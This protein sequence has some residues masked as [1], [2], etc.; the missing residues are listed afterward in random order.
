MTQGRENQNTDPRGSLGR[1]PIFP[2]MQSMSAL[3]MLS[4]S[5]LPPT[6]GRCLVANG[7]K[8]LGTS[9]GAMPTPSSCT[10]YSS[11]KSPPTAAL[12]SAPFLLSPLVD[13]AGETANGV[14][15]PGA[16]VVGVTPLAGGVR[17]RLAWRRVPFAGGSVVKGAAGAGAAGVG[18]R[19]ATTHTLPPSRENFTAL[20]S[21]LEH[22]CRILVGSALTKLG[23]LSPITRC[24]WTS[25][26]RANWRRETSSMI[27]FTSRRR[28]NAICSTVTRPSLTL[29]RSSTSSTIVFMTEACVNR[30]WTFSLTISEG[31]ESI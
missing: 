19:R 4:P 23:T 1:A 26:S 22:T 30:S 7:W 31:S 2:P 17:G 21:S 6:S 8:S 5:P 18:L 10:S 15:A 12:A 13:E 9:C 11:S 25:L 29:L 14:A 16:P 28:S 27:D 24:S 3:Q 20:L